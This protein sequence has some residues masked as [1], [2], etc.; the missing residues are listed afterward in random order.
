M[1]VELHGF[2]NITIELRGIGDPAD[3]NSD[4]VTGRITATFAD[5]CTVTIVPRGI[6]PEGRQRYAYIVT[7][8]I[9]TGED[10]RSGVG[11]P[12]NLIRALAA[13]TSF[14][15]ADAETYW[16][17]VSCDDPFADWT[18]EHD[19]ELSMLGSGLQAHPLY[20]G[21]GGGA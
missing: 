14:A 11:E 21:S 10:L 12:V 8:P 4:G 16:T 3:C 7:E 9:S 2:G 18:Y 5:G 19:D 20:D 17:S 15:S 6:C 13:W 1:S